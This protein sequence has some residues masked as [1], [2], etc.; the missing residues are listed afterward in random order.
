MKVTNFNEI[1][2]SKVIPVLKLNTVLSRRIEEWR[3][4]CTHTLNSVIG[5]DISTSSSGRCTAGKGPTV[6]TKKEV[7]WDPQSVH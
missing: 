3:C 2:K 4:I 6:P 1:M 5:R 7:G